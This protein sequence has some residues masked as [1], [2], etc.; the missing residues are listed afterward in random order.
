MTSGEQLVALVLYTIVFGFLVW[1]PIYLGQKAWYTWVSYVRGAVYAKIEY[2]LLELR[3][4]KGIAKSPLA[5]EVFLNTL[6]Q[7]SGE[8][9]KYD[10]Y[11]KGTTRAWFSLEIVSIEGVVRFFIWT[12]E[13]HAHTIQTQIY[14]QF[15]NIEVIDMDETGEGDY[16]RRLVYDTDT[17]KFWCGEFRK[18]GADHLPIRTYV[19]YG[20]DKDPKEEFKVDPITP[21]IEYMGSLG[22]G[23]QAWIQ[24]GVRAHSKG[25]PKEVPKDKRKEKK[26]KWYQSHEIV[27]WTDAA[28]E[29]IKKIAKRDL[30]ATDDKPISAAE[31]K[32]TKPEEE[33][34]TSI[35][36]SISKLAFDTT[37]RG[38]YVATKDAFLPAHS[39]AIGGCFKQYN[40]MHLNSFEVKS[41][42][43]K[44]A[45]QDLGGRKV[46]ADKKKI[47][48]QYQFRAFFYDEF[49]PVGGG[50]GKGNKWK[51]SKY[52]SGVPFVMNIE[53]LA[54]VFHFPGDVARTPSLTRIEAKKGEAP[55]N[56]P[57]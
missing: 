16:A 26:L 23:E 37:I 45:W 55:A 24:I 52:E 17:H 5:M 3:I 25:I 31:L 48:E 41:P 7:P 28:K 8:G 46:E 14:G 34:I 4:P 33:K 35:E 54:T 43:V 12:Q 39:A 30:K 36:R 42:N 22:K 9:D 6:F 13:K 15:P 44:Y 47:F 51:S 32:L 38:V 27:D 49:L 50:G 40:T 1:L 19:D 56:L 57:I 18:K 53:E 10:K 20:L 29:D 11:W 2:K 21:L